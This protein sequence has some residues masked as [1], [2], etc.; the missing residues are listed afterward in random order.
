YGVILMTDRLRQVFTH[1][2]QLADAQQ[3]ALA[4]KWAE[5]LD[6]LEWDALTRKPGAHAFHQRLI[7]EARQARA[8]GEIEDIDGDAF[9]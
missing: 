7:E 9:V 5:D 4:A 6:E 1:A 3:D 8:K 2:E